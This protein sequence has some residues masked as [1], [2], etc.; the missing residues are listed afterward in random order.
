VVR[1]SEVSSEFY[2]M[3]LAPCGSLANLGGRCPP[4]VTSKKLSIL[5]DQQE[6]MPLIC[7]DDLH[8]R[9]RLFQM[10]KSLVL[11]YKTQLVT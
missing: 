8:N 5:R 9:L 2:V 7:A 1:S 10:S 3:A 6:V 11:Y 4:F